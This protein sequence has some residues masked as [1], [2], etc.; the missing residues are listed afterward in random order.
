MGGCR[1]NYASTLFGFRTLPE[2]FQMYLTTLDM[3]AVMIALVVSVTLVITTAI[4]NAR[5]T[6]SRDN[7]R[8]SYLQ[9]SSILNDPRMKDVE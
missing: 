2:R 8:Q 3:L 1:G 6:R 4:A 5:L 9:M 7:W